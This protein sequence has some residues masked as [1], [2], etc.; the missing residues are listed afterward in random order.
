MQQEFVERKRV[1]CCLIS[2]EASKFGDLQWRGERERKKEQERFLFPHLPSG[3]F[4]EKKE[5]ERHKGKRKTV[6]TVHCR[7]IILI[8]I[9]LGY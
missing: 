6:F 4:N 9:D 2:D 1:G 3:G 8:I 5:K 7:S